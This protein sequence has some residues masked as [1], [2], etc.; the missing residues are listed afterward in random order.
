MLYNDSTP[1][2]E[3]LK[4]IIKKK[5]QDISYHDE[6]MQSVCMQNHDHNCMCNCSGAAWRW[7]SSKQK[8]CLKSELL[9]ARD[10][11]YID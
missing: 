1:E 4:E 2:K 10:Y 6:C 5:Y 11:V 8:N 3:Q 7:C 9:A